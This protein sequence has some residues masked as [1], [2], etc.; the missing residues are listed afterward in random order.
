MAAPKRRRAPPP[1][2]R[3]TA[4]TPRSTKT[5]NENETH[6]DIYSELLSEATAPHQQDYVSE[7]P[8]KRRRAGRGSTSPGIEAQSD[9]ASDMTDAPSIA[10]V[11]RAKQTVYN[12]SASSDASEDESW[13]E[14]Q[15]LPEGIGPTKSAVL[16]GDFDEAQVE[17]ISLVLD[18]REAKSTKRT[19]SKRVPSTVVE[20]AKRL[21]IHKIHVSCLLMHVYFRNAWCNLP[22]VQVSTL[23]ASN[24]R[25]EH[26][27][28]YPESFAPCTKSTYADLS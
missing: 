22:E 5:A 6:A 12:D 3:S 19:I 13:E 9:H 8:R 2:P 25:K 17:D 10:S 23:M 14:V 16:N 1:K 4:R 15:L 24:V 21:S 7:R 18:K 26:E 27:S 11:A 20:K 28:N